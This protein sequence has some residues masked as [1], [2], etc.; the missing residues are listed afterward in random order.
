MKKIV[1]Y[2]LCEIFRAVVSNFRESGDRSENSNFFLFAPKDPFGELC[3]KI[4]FKIPANFYFGKNWESSKSAKTCPMAQLKLCKLV[5]FQN[6]R[7]RQGS[8]FSS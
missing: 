1:V 4:I 6:S 2:L 8:V 3:S 5:H 7:S